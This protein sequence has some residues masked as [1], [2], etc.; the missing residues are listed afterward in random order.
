MLIMANLRRI[1]RQ[2]ID[3]RMIP[4]TASLLGVLICVRYSSIINIPMP[5]ISALSAILLLS[6]LQRHMKICYALVSLLLYYGMTIALHPYP[7]LLLRVCRFSAFAIALLLF[8][9]LL[10]SSELTSIRKLL[11]KSIVTTLSVMVVISFVLW[12]YWTVLD[13]GISDN[14]LYFY[15][16]RGIFDK[17]MTLS[18]VAGVIALVGLYYSLTHMGFSR[19]IWVVISIMGVILTIAAGSRISVFGLVIALILELL[20]MREQLK[21]IAKTRYATILIVATIFVIAISL[22]FAIKTLVYKSILCEINDSFVMSRQEIWS[23]RF[24]EILTSPLTG[25][26]YANEFPRPSWLNSVGKLTY[27][28]PGSSW[29]SL[30]SYGGVIGLGIFCWFSIILAKKIM[31]NFT[32]QILPLTLL[33]FLF[34]NGVTEGWLLFGG[35]LMFPIFWLSCSATFNPQSNLLNE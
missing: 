30:V 28:E 35:A 5:I 33:T 24:D 26:G 23:T 27:L 4:A 1:L 11:F 19:V 21:L 20:L 3:S 8:S 12:V 25:I 14:S 17:G 31:R 16:F 34:I 2:T 9:P 18:P 29:L 22:P 7:E 32:Q 15:G 6:C 10:I 13:Y